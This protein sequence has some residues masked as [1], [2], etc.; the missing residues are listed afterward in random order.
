MICLSANSRAIAL[1]TGLTLVLACAPAMAQRG[2]PPRP[3]VSPHETVSA[4]IGGNRVTVTYG[5]PYSKAPTGTEIRKIWGTLVPYGK[6][7]RAGS[8]EATTLITQQPLMFGTT[9][10]PAGAYSLFMLPN[11]D[12]TA[13]LVISKQIGHWG[14]QYDEKQ[15]FARVDMTKKEIPEQVDQFTMA[16]ATEGAGGVL[17]M[18]WERAEYSAAFTVKK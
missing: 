7:W 5:R 6:V 18:T 8:D 3:R 17:K 2:G 1:A 12:G 14:T 16:V 15:D 9:E 10:L 11:E 4:V 13:K